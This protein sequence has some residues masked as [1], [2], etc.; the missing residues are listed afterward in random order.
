LMLLAMAVGLSCYTLWYFMQAI[1]DPEQAGRDLKGLGKRVGQLIKGFIHVGLVLAIVRLMIGL[2]SDESTD[3]RTR[4]WTAWV[5]AFP[6]G[7]WLVGGT[8]VGVL[9][10]GVYQLYR[11]WRIK[12]DDQL[13]LGR[14]GKTSH[15]VIVSL[16]R[17]GLFARGVL[18]GTIGIFLIVA[19]MRADPR[20]AKGVASAMRALEELWYGSLALSAVAL[21]LFSYGLYQF[22]RAKYRRIA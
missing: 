15:T 9:G 1:L 5:M 3:A 12:L 7:I 6:L 20:Q 21:G 10:Y 22:L 17:F 19:A 18:F 14:F 13:E 11:A 4:D 8:G 2:H 16:S